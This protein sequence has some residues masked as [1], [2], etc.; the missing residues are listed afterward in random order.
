M[1]KSLSFRKKIMLA[2]MLTVSVGLAVILGFT[3]IANSH[4]ARRQ[5]E[6]LA[7]QMASRYAEQTEQSLNSSMKVAT[8]L[9][10]TMEGMRQGSMQGLRT[11]NA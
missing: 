10:Q 11:R 8:L 6:E 5:G 9:A 1:L 7:R 4:D 2:V 3:N